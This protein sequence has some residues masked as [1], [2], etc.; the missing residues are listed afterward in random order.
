MSVLVA[1]NSSP[2]GEAAL[3]AGAAEAALRQ[4]ALLWCNL[5]AAPIDTEAIL[6]GAVATEVPRN[7]DQ[8]PAD[9]VLDA[10]VE[11]E[12]TLLVVGIKRRSPVGKL[13]MGSLAQRLLLD[14][15]VPVLAVKSDRR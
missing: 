9:A 10:A 1:T 8:D 7:R 4:T 12:A 11:H 2:E 3:R 14:A 5:G 13:I 15:N 6:D